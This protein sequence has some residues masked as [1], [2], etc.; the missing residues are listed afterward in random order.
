MIELTRDE[1]VQSGLHAVGPRGGEIEQRPPAGDRQRVV[2]D[3]REIA[4]GDVHFGQRPAD[5]GAM[6]HVRPPRP[7]ALEEVDDRRGPAGEPA[8]DLALAVARRLRARHAALGEM[9]HQRQEIRQ[10]VLRHALLI[11]R[12]DVG[13]LA[14]VQQEVRILDALG[15]ALVGEQF[16]D[17]VAFEEFREV[18]GGNVGVDRHMVYS[19][20]A[21]SGRSERGSG[22]NSFSSAAET[23]STCSS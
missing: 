9:R 3:Q 20:A 6:R 1:V 10:V 16:A 13:A 19:A 15:D 8:G 22:K 7:H 17:V 14:G 23:V 2:A 5:A 18:F 12:E 4:A 21:A 11:E